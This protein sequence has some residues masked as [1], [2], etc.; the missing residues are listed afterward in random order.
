[1]HPAPACAQS[2]DPRDYR[3][4]Q[5]VPREEVDRWLKD[6][7]S[8]SGGDLE[9]G[10]YH[11]VLGFSTGHYGSDPVHAIAM[12]RLAFSLLNNTFAPGDRVTPVAWEMS[13]WDKGQEIPLTD[14]PHPR[15]AFVDAVPSAPQQ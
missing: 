4:I 5:R 12:R 3:I 10:R 13:V 8:H 6:E 7:F 14:D 15:A 2:T 9:K 11:F 1:L